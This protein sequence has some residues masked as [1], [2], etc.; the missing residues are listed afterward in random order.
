MAKFILVIDSD[1]SNNEGSSE[2]SQRLEILVEFEMRGRGVGPLATALCDKL[3]D[4]P[5]IVVIRSVPSSSLD[6]TVD[7]VRSVSVK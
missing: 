5:S 7:Q 3:L 4:R 2:E 1:Y 6:I